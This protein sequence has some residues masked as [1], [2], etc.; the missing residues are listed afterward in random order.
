MDGNYLTASEFVTAV[1]SAAPSEYVLPAPTTSRNTRS[2]EG[3]AYLDFGCELHQ[4]V[5]AEL[6]FYT[7]HFIDHFLCPFPDAAPFVILI[8][9]REST[10][11]FERPDAIAYGRM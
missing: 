2:R 1:V 10:I 7:R 3:G 5:N 4:V 6:P 11:H 9:R 8:A